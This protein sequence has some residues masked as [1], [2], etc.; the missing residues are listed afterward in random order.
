MTL[1]IGLTG[2]IGSGKSTVSAFF[3][4][5][6]V[7]V[8]DADLVSRQVVAK[9]Q[10]GLKK[11]VQHFGPDILTDGELNR[12]RLREIVFQDNSEREWLNKLLHPLIHAR[13]I[14]ELAEAKG[15]YV[16]LEAPLL[17]ENGLEALTDYNLVVDVAPELQI[18]RASARDGVSLESVKAIIAKQID[19]AKRL[20]KADFVIDNSGVLLSELKKRV[21]D[22]D[23]QFRGLQ[24][25]S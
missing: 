22:L 6:H 8:V 10:P 13:I 17:F 18:Q 5:L 7:P 20:Q 11:I 24:K 9:G 16:L 25:K 2:G 1:I 14:S 23:R 3:S 21:L 4:A 19:R 12:S 15:K